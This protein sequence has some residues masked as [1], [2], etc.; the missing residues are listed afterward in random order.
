MGLQK[1]LRYHCPSSRQDSIHI[2]TLDTIS[3][4]LTVFNGLYALMDFLISCDDGDHFD[5]IKYHAFNIPALKRYFN[6]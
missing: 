1:T 3:I 2:P 5:Y 6:R 4:F